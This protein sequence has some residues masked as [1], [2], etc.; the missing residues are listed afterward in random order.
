MDTNLVIQ[1]YPES[2]QRPHRKE[3]DEEATESRWCETSV[4]GHGAEPDYQEAEPDV[5]APQM[6]VTDMVE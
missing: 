1:I 6:G 3:G 5:E 4:R 2:K